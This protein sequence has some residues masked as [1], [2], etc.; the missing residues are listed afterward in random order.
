MVPSGKSVPSKS[1]AINFII[2]NALS[3]LTKSTVENFIVIFVTK[4]P[5]DAVILCPAK[6]LWTI[7]L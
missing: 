3:S 2:I 5:Q 6:S 1:D 4:S 7:I